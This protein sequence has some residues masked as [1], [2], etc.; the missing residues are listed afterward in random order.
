VNCSDF[1]NNDGYGVEA[2][3]H[4]L[5]DLSGDS[6]IGNGAGPYTVSGGGGALVRRNPDCD[7]EAEKTRV[8]T[9][10]PD[11]RTLMHVVHVVDGQIVTLDCTAYR[12]TVLVLANGDQVVLPCPTTGQASLASVDSDELPAALD[13]RLAFVSAMEAQVFPVLDGIMLVDFIIPFGQSDA[14]FSILR[15]DD[16]RWADLQGVR[17]EEGFFEA[18]SSQDGVFVLVSE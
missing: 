3:L 5:L 4:G 13:S 9:S 11:T 7:P 15:W 2:V 14:N 6:F 16:T 8:P 12:G 10:T 17:T 1:H 18:L